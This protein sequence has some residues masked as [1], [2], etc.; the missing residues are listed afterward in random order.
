MRLIAGI[1]LVGVLG[2]GLWVR[3]APSDP[4][5]W[6]VAPPGAAKRW[7][8]GLVEV[9]A[10]DPALLARLVEVAE[11]TPRTTLLAGSVDEAQ[12]TFVT[13]SLWWGF[14]DYITISLSGAHI[15]LHARLR[16]GRSDFG[17][18][19]TRVKAWLQSA[20]SVDRR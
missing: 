10:G 15:T 5:R 16:F 13:R 18:N 1:V 12:V 17:V 9:V 6:H 3:F 14:P 20:Q 8:G 4:A 2:F 7:D 11:A 19:A